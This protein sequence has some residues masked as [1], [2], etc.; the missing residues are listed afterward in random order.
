MTILEFNNVS[1]FFKDGQATVEILKNANYS[2][3]QG[4]LYALLGPSGSGK[5]TSLA[6]AGGLDVPK[7]GKVCY[8]GKDLNDIGYSTY[9]KSKRAMVFQSYNLLPYLTAFQNVL[10]GIEIAN[11]KVA[12]KKE[13]A[14]NT[15]KQV[16]LTVEEANRNVRKL[17]GGQQQRV[18]IAR[19]LA[20]D[21][22]LILA[23]EPTGNLDQKTAEGTI[24][25]FKR[26]AHDEQKCVIIVTHDQD[27]AKAA[28]QVIELTH[29]HFIQKLKD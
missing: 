11:S 10:T 20:S 5:T 27:I 24:D 6:L 7:T 21:V 18:A 23:D 3:E 16:G 9:R 14:I 28:D 2:F 22:D 29:G 1:Y 19:A 13:H 17:S 26:L 25:I 4:K 15:L 8:Q 12:N